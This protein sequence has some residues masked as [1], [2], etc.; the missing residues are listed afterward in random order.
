LKSSRL[1]PTSHRADFNFT[2][3][4]LA[5]AQK[6]FTAMAMK[7]ALTPIFFTLALTFTACGDKGS[8]SGQ[9][10]PFSGP[11]SCLVKYDGRIT[12][13][14]PLERV[15]TIIDIG[16]ADPKQESHTGSS[17]KSVSWSWDSDRQR[18]MNIAGQT[19]S[20]PMSNQV[21][22]SQFKLVDQEEFGPKDAKSYVEANY[23]SI[24]T[25]EMASIQARMKEQIQKRVEK[26][27]LTAEQAALA[28]GMGEGLVGKER[29]VDTIDGVGDACRW[30]ATDKTLAVGHR[31]VFFALFVD[32]AADNDL[33]RDKAVELAKL[34]LAECD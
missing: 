20:V 21:S 32:I 24:S 26:G 7:S 25:E 30:T 29:V 19:I 11:K 33:N 18:E 22:V 12:D 3:K 2:E 16:T 28:G 34:I 1:L 23:R 17:M 8:S 14:L 4:A 13:L 6:S 5:K 27:E 9:S 15:K 31:N 10:A